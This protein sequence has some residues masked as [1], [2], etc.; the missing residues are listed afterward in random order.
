MPLALRAAVAAM[1]AWSA[2]LPF[3]GVAAEY[4]YYAPL[5]AVVVVATSVTR[6]VRTSAQALLSLLLGAA[7]G[8]VAHVLPGPEVLA[9]GVVV[10]LGT[11]VAAWGPLGS[12]AGWVPISALFILVLGGDDPWPYVGAYVGLTTAGALVGIVV[13]VSVPPLLIASQR[14]VQDALRT[15]LSEQLA[16][17]AAAL[18]QDPPPTREE[19]ESYRHHLGPQIE[20]VNELV[21]QADEGSR[22]NW[23]VR[24]WH[25][26]SAR[27]HRHGRALVSLAYL[28]EDLTELVAD[29]ERA[30]LEEV[31][32]GPTLRPAAAHALRAAATALDSV[33]DDSVAGPRELRRARRA[34]EGFGAA[35]RSARRRTDRDQFAAGALLTGLRRVLDSVAPA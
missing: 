21:A 16:G 1:L 3:G 33:G 31:A 2:V 24:R 34:L 6:T 15:A 18:E 9:L 20:R 28:V 25:E 27:Q 30:E 23:R 14:R 22:I 7:L 13:N 8:L 5:G 19:W 12:M 4:A 17:L 35:I 11:L 26:L 10:A 32:L 29:R